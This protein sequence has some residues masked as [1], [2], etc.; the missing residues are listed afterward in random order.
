MFNK[1]VI[2]SSLLFMLLFNIGY[3]AEDAGTSMIAVSPI[4]DTNVLITDI[5]LIPFKFY[6]T[7]T[8][9]NASCSLFLKNAV[10]NQTEYF[11]NCT[12]WNNTVTTMYPNATFSTEITEDWQW[13]VNCSI[14]CEDFSTWKD[15][16]TWQNFS[17]NTGQMSN[18]LGDLGT[19]TASLLDDLADP[20]S[21][22]MLT[23]GIVMSV[24]GLLWS[25][26]FMLKL[27]L[28]NI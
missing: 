14:G 7:S 25:I 8:V 19:G 26:V 28:A 20:I 2:L 9:T 5:T 11:H 4:S 13:I 3:S 18:S 27:K 15:M 1:K 17:F 21:S 10:T 22:F 23:F 12:T 16:D 6:F 24:L